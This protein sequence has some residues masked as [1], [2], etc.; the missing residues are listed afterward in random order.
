MSIMGK[1][2]WLLLSHAFNM[3]GR[4]ASLT[5]TDKIPYFLAAGVKPIVLS[6]ITGLK[7]Q[8]F[9]HEQFWPGVLQL[10][11]LIFAT[12]L[13]I[14]MAVVLFTSYLRVPYQSC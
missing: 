12:G 14:N 8:R 11:V 1:K 7:D 13:R 10:S 6:A 5:I 4:A 3:D 9:P 2:N